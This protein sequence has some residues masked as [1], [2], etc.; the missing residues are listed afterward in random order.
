MT[1]CYEEEIEKNMNVKKIFWHFMSG[2]FNPINLPNLQFYL[3][4][5]EGLT[6]IDGDTDIDSWHDLSPNNF[7][8][9][10]LT[11]FSQLRANY[12]ATGLNGN[13]CADFATSDFAFTSAWGAKLSKTVPF[14]IFGK[15]RFDSTAS[16][17]QGILTSSPASDDRFQ[18]SLT[19][20]TQLNFAYWDGAAWA[21]LRHTIAANTDYWFV[22]QQHVG[23]ITP[24]LWINGVEILTTTTTNAGIAG[25]GIYVIGSI[26]DTTTGSQ[27]DG[28]ISRL[29]FSSTIE[30]EAVVQQINNYLAT[31]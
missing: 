8:G 21:G 18:I 29:G 10:A 12:S 2:G 25:N 11:T 26:R 3:T 6:L 19:S 7:N 23:T 30:S 17:S 13:P 27:F 5:E 28:K 24:R 4:A 9:L 22:F 1:S 20:N 15:K 14:T 16:V 31:A